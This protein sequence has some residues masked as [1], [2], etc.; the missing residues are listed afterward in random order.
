MHLLD[1]SQL[2]SFQIHEI[3]DLTEKLTLKQEG[4][5]LDGKTFILFFPESSLRTRITFEKGIKDLGGRMR[6]ISA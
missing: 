6:L 2:S 1:I 4:N 5:I 3:F